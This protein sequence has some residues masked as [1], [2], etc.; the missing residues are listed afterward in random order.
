MMS[1]RQSRTLLSVV[2]LLMVVALLFAA[3]VEAGDDIVLKAMKD[4][5]ARSMAKLQLEKLEKPYFISYRVTD[6]T[7][8]S[9]SASFGSL[10]TAANPAHSRLLSVEVR[11]GDY[12]FDNTNFLGSPSFGPGPLGATFTGAFFLP[13][14][15]DYQAIRRQ[16]WL[17]TDAAYKKAVEDLSKK[18][19]ALQNKTRT[20][21]LPDFT[22]VDPA[23]IAAPAVAPSVN[24]QEA[25]ALVRELSAAFRELPDVFSSRV[26]L[27]FSFRHTIY[28]NS[29]G[30]TFIRDAPLVTLAVSAETQANDGMPLADSFSFYGQ[31]ISDLPAKA[32]VL[33]AIRESGANL[34]KLRQAPTL[35]RYNGPVLL[36]GQA[37]ASAFRQV[38]AP[39]LLATRRPITERPEFDAT[40]SQADNPFNDRLGSRVLPTSLS[41]TDNPT[42]NEFA[43]TP[44]IGARKVDDEGVVTRAVRL[45]EKGMLKTLLATRVPSTGIANTTGSRFG[46]GPLPS[47]LLVTAENGKSDEELR[48]ELFRLVKER[49]NEFGIVIKRI[50]NSMLNQDSMQFQ[51]LSFGGAGRPTD[52]LRNIVLAYKVYPDGREELIRNA[53]ISGFTVQSFKEIVGVSNTPT[54]ISEPFGSRPIFFNPYEMAGGDTSQAPV[55]VAVPALL[56][57]ELTL[58][59]P[60]GEIPKLPVAKHPFFDR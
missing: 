57:E 7:T 43:K 45:V 33:K 53:L 17:A 52:E 51:M 9:V 42:I 23:N 22:R 14:D 46:I 32:E 16:I 36:E 29:E 20:E 25:E 26:D 21:D 4:E 40:V 39:K 30:T 35:E 38:F 6:L 56:F 58:K 3:R 13:L 12:S 19:A 1:I 49:G 55:S 60:A 8:T 41:V 24:R 50:G 54:V 10:L 5:L 28:A 11:V 48:Q 34:A 2:T 47:N 27:R 15:D 37:A 18:R 59:K 31:S 44:L